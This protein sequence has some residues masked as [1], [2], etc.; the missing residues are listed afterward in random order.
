M[1]KPIR[2][3]DS[4]I[5]F[6]DN[7][8][9]VHPFLNEY[10]ANYAAFVGDYSTMARKY[11]LDDYLRDS[12]D[13]QIDG[14][15]WHE[16]LS[17]DPIKEAN[18]A[19]NLAN[20]SSLAQSMVVIVDFLDPTLERKLEFYSSLS[21]VT[22]IREHMVWDNENPKKRFAKRPNLLSDPTWQKGLEVLNKYDF[23]CGLEVFAP[24]LNELMNVIQRYPNVGFTL[25]VMGWPL[26]VSIEGY[27]Q[28]R[29]DIKR[30]SQYQNICV[31]I[32]AIECIFGMDWTL[33]QVR[34]WILSVIEFFGTTRCMF[35]SHM[36][37]AKLSRSF[38]NLYN[39]YENL[40]ANFSST[41]KANLFHNVAANWFKLFKE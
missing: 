30:L 20:Q 25:A 5:H 11:L 23:K 27:K 9:N 34:P 8:A 39:T 7:K 2:I 12:F 17:T 6:Y 14:V 26:D 18:W 28:W 37:I 13:Y 15:V 32:S 24:Q 38:A 19:Q 16:F 1:S 41:E 4:H 3:I 21:N 29:Q 40:T 31:D 22:A 10:D 33:N 35:G 36:P